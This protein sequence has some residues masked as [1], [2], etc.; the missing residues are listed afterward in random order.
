MTLE[1]FYFLSQIAAALGIMASLIFVGVQVRQSTRQAKAAAAQAVHDNFAN[2]YLSFSEHPHLSEIGVKGLAGLDNLTPEETMHFVT[3][4][5][6]VMSYTQSAFLKWREGDLDDELWKSW[7]RSSLSYYD[8]KGGKEVWALRK[9][10]FTPAFVEYVEAN[11]LNTPLPQGAR[12]W[13][14]DADAPEQQGSE[15]SE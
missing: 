3:S 12:P 4:I 1:D 5:L 15:A 6:A 7:E 13:I 9:Y 11:L 10:A 2:W 8:T 14:K